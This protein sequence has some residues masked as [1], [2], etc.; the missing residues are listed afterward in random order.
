[1]NVAEKYHH[2]TLLRKYFHHLRDNVMDEQHEQVLE[3]Q[4]DDYYR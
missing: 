1:M 3:K 4:A 2:S